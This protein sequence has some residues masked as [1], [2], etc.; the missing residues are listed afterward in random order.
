MRG[1]EK[2]RE[3]PY[4]SL[5]NEPATRGV[6]ILHNR[7]PDRIRLHVPLIKQRATLAELLKHSLLKDP[8]AQG[9]YHAEPNV[10]TGSL[11]IKY[12]PALHSEAQVVELVA[13]TARR[14]ADGQ[15]PISSKH[16]NPR[17]SRMPPGAY[18][19]RELV[20]SV[21]GNVLAGLALAVFM[22]R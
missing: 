12:H 10:A 9:I 19:T 20:V 6:R 21:V 22:A 3:F 17:V 2:R 13:T 8:D 15:V 18:F 14:I 5:M 11:L 1:F 7:V 4:A 16:R